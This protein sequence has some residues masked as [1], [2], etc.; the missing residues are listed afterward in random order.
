MIQATEELVQGIR[1][2]RKRL[3]QAERRL[4]AEE[5]RVE[6]ER[7]PRERWERFLA[8]YDFVG[9]LSDAADSDDSTRVSEDAERER[10]ERRRGWIRFHLQRSI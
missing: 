8:F 1:D 6:R 4:L 9:R 2:R 3:A 10:N 7:S 5:A